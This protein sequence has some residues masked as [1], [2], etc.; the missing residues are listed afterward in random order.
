MTASVTTDSPV[1]PLTISE[2]GGAITGVRWGRDGGDAATPLLAAAVRQL[3]A[4]FAGR[5]T[6]F[7]LP[8]DAHG[9]AFDLRVWAAMRQIPY[10]RTASYSDLAREIGSAPRAIGGAC[11]RNP[12]PIVI[13][14]HRV[15]A[16]GGLG[17]YSGGAGLPTKQALLALERAG[18][19]ALAVAG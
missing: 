8:L 14:C 15:L 13:P 18:M 12:I 3:D 11:G 19:P 1:G 6:R 5:L 2:A 16:Q 7:D 10:G 4:Y 9:S 17:G